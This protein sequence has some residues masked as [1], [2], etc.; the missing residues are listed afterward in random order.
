MG[1]WRRADV[2]SLDAQ[3]SV[4]WLWIMYHDDLNLPIRRLASLSN[5]YCHI[6]FRSSMH[7]FFRYATPNNLVVLWSLEPPISAAV[8]FK[9]HT[10]GYDL[11]VPRPRWNEPIF[12]H[13]S[14]DSKCS[15]ATAREYKSLLSTEMM[16]S[17]LDTRSTLF[18]LEI[19]GT[20][21][22]SQ[23]DLRASILTMSGGVAF[24]QPGVVR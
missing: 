16:F 6:L 23:W 18:H 24:R 21:C 12:D 14:L 10:S 19:V 22:W 1:L 17:H 15:S 5:P 20:T 13:T 7:S 4:S 11:E 3:D 8:V 2:R 9:L